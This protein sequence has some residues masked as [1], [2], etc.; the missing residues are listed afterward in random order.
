M[1]ADGASLS[2]PEGT[3]DNVP[4]AITVILGTVLALSLG[5]ALIKAIGNKLSFGLWQLFALRSVIALPILVAF[6][7]I[8]RPGISLIPRRVGWA[9]LRSALLFAMWLAYYASLPQMPLAVAAAAYYT[10]PLF[11][12]AFA[13]AVGG[14]RVSGPQWA[15]VVLGFGGVLLV[16]RPAGDAFSGWVLLPLLAAALYA[17]AMV[18]TRLQC[19]DEH[20]LVLAI[21]LNATFIAAGGA[22][23]L[24]GV[25]GVGGDAGFLSTAWSPLSLADA[26]SLTVLGVLIVIASFGTALAYQSAPSSVVGA[27]DFAYVAFALAWGVLFFGEFLE[28][29]GLVGI[30]LI[31]AAGVLA[32]RQPR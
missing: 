23:L 20:P 18:I 32:V 12:V 16:L 4:F 22:G 31:V 13:A 5:D 17:A 30:A 11:I 3:R 21:A 2:E 24:A 10:L 9:A 19:R 29:V 26:L 7:V 14:E 27:F 28:P 6:A 25:L 15:G 1:S 8:L